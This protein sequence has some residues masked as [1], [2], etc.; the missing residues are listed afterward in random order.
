MKPQ[1]QSLMSKCNF[2]PEAAQLDSERQLEQFHKELVIVKAS[3]VSRWCKRP[4]NSSFDESLKKIQRKLED[5]T[6][7]LQY[8]PF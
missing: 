7:F 2:K 3:D 4:I 8:V 5:W 1:L 6:Q